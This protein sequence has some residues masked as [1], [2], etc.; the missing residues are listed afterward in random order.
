M[1]A[2]NVRLLPTDPAAQVSVAVLEKLT[3][4]TILLFSK[5][6]TFSLFAQLCS[7]DIFFLLK[8][9]NLWEQDVCIKY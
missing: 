6:I 3:I 5:F 7:N 2:D 9:I 1:K 4:A 8:R